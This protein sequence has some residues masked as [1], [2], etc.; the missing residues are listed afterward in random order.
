L[1][2][3]LLAGTGGAAYRPAM[4]DSVLT[5]VVLPLALAVIMATLGLSL[6]VADFRR[7]VRQPRAVL[8]GLA[9]LLVV[10]PLLAFAA[11]EVFG[12]DPILAVGLVLL[13]A[14]PGGTL[15]NLLTHLA[16][17]E[18]ALSVTMTAVSSVAAVV[19][20]PLYL[21]LAI[22]HFDAGLGDE[23]SMGGIVLKVLFITVVPL[24]LGM[25][26]RSRRPE[27]A[28][29]LEPRVKKLALVIFVLV[30]AGA[31]VSEFDA[32]RDSIGA[33]AFAALALNVAAMSVSFGVARLARLGDRRATAI[34]MELGVHNSTLTIT[35]AA[36]IHPEL[37]IP[38]AV[39]SAFM[40]VTAGIFARVMAA[41]NAA[42]ARAPEPV[43][44]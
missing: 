30:V 15:A 10:S 28:V 43:A 8:I 12:L 39:Y 3:G 32:V 38:G 31:V 40:F 23:V 22:D 20:V 21:G 5:G 9:N 19:T 4:S 24:S 36:G 41:R 35:V 27:R 11:A 6:T 42:P 33:V 17:G 7:V 25:L 18:T 29:A 26:Y 2:T 1:V 44:A 13:G 14:S 34:A 16:R 37:A